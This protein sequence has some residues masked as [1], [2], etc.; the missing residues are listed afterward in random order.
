MVR[1]PKN[2]SNTLSFKSG[3]IQTGANALEAELLGEKAY[4]LGLSAR[5]LENAL[6]TLKTFQGS[7]GE[8]AVLLQSTADSVQAFFIQREMM[9][10]TNH[11]HPIEYYQIPK[12]VLSKVGV[13]PSLNRK[14]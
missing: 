6:H 12:A 14:T 4:S 5:S 9:G 3:V 13:K 10:F 2:L 11:E 1:L 7:E 8:R